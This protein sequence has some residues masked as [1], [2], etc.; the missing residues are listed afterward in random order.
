MAVAQEASAVQRA[1]AARLVS[2][3]ALLA[4]YPLSILPPHLE[5][6]FGQAPAGIDPEPFPEMA[7][8]DL[9]PKASGSRI[10]DRVLSEAA[11][12]PPA[13]RCRRR[14]PLQSLGRTAERPRAQDTLSG[15]P[16]ERQPIWRHPYAY[17]SGSII[18]GGNLPPFA[19]SIPVRAIVLLR[20]LEAVGR[21]TCGLDRIAPPVTALE[22]IERHLGGV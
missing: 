20:I 15:P 6:G 22:V 16:H 18:P 1:L 21:P 5:A 13:S 14:W 17:N 12:L 11:A 7:A 8:A 2:A 3:G 19:T 9:F 4:G 10:W